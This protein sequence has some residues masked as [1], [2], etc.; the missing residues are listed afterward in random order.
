MSSPAFQ[1]CLYSIDLAE[2]PSKAPA[3]PN[4]VTSQQGLP[5]ET[6]TSTYVMATRTSILTLSRGVD[7]WVA[8]SN[9][10]LA[11]TKSFPQLSWLLRVK[12]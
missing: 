7:R 12:S 8:E 3:V 1:A 11:T 10:S 6:E 5:E 4:N 2:T 9:A